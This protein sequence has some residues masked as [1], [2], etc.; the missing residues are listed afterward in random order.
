LGYSEFVDELDYT[1]V[2]ADAGLIV[3]SHSYR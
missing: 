2:L 1:M 3:D